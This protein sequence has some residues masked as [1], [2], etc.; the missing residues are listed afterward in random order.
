MHIREEIGSYVNSREE[1]P[2]FV[3]YSVINPPSLLSPHTGC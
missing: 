2:H 3:H 1:I